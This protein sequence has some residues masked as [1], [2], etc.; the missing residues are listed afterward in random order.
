MKKLLIFLLVAELVLA[1]VAIYFQYILHREGYEKFWG[2]F[3]LLMFLV[4]MPLFLWWRYKDRD[5]SSWHMQSKQ[6][7]NPPRREDPQ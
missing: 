2:F 7:K 4:I 1:S 5:L 3:T 6:K